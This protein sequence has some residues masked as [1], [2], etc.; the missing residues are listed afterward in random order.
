MVHTQ[1]RAQQV[2]LALVV[3]AAV[4]V[5]M[6]VMVVLVATQHALSQTQSLVS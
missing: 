4:V 1:Y 3:L 5:V 2:V 6:V